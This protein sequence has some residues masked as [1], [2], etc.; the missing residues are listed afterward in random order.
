MKTRNLL[1]DTIPALLF[2]EQSN[3]VFLYLHGKNGCKE[4][5]FSLADIVCPKGYQ[6][7][8]IDLPKHGERKNDSIEFT[9]WNVIPELEAVLNYIKKNWKD[10]SL[11]ANS[12]GAWFA[13]LAY[14]NELFPICL[15]VSPILDME[16]LIRTMMTWAN[17]TE[18]ELEEKKKY[19]QI[20]MKP[21]HG[22]TIHLRKNIRFLLGIPLPV[23]YMVIKIP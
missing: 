12:I 6:V 1:I 20:L 11:Y 18:K 9:P 16:Q 13:M 14:S 23:F 17:V 3:I 15:F 22:T 2:G 4:E 5:A 10:C 21:C 8:S 19:Q 7:L